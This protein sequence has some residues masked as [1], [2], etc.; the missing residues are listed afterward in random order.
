MFGQ[1]TKKG[2]YLTSKCFPLNFFSRTQISE[3]SLCAVD[4]SGLYS[5][6]RTTQGTNQKAPFH[7]GPVH[8]YKSYGEGFPILT[9]CSSHEIEDSIGATRTSPASCEH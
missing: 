5:T 3:L 9:T 2:F 1:T 8:P 7:L 6:I 4:L